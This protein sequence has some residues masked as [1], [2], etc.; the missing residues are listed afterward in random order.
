M[1]L[2]IFHCRDVYPVKDILEVNFSKRK[3]TVKEERVKMVELNLAMEFIYQE[4]ILNM[5]SLI[6]QI[7]HHL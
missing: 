2:I 4:I 7:L 3:I 1:F 6:F 5:L